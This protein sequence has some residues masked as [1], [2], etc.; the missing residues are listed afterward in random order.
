MRARLQQ[1][2]R[3]LLYLLG[4]LLTSILALGV[5]I[6]GLSIALSLAVFIVAIPA[7]VLVAETFRWTAEL[8]RQNARLLLGAPITSGYRRAPGEGVWG[9]MKATLTD[10]Q[11]FRD[12][13]WLIVH[14]VVGMTFGIL[15]L[16]LVLEPFA[17]ATLPGWWDRS[18]DNNV[19]QWLGATSQGDAWLVAL[20]AIPLALL[21]VVLL[22]GM[23]SAHVGLAQWFLH[24]RS[25][26]SVH[27]APTVVVTPKT[28]Y[29]PAAAIA[30]HVSVAAAI[31]LL[32][33]VIW[34]FTGGTF[35]PVW[36]W[37]GL[38]AS[39]IAHVGVVRVLQAPDRVLRLRVVAELAA[40]LV[41]LC[42]LVWLLTGLGT[43]WPVWPAIGLAAALGF[44]ALLIAAPWR[45]DG[46]LTER[47]E[48]LT[49]TRRDAVDAQATELRRIERDL[50]D[51][52][53]ARLVALTMQLGR[54][55]A[56]LADHP[57]EAELVRQARGEASAAI[58]ELRDL[59]R[60]IAPPVLVD[61]GLVAAVEALAGR[62]PMP[63]SVTA[64]VDQRLPVA[65]E[66]A[67]YFVCAEALTNAAKHASGADV[68]IRLERDATSLLVS[69]HD[70]GPGG[71]DA[72]GSGLTGLRQRVAALDGTLHV[73]SASGQGTT[74]SA[75]LSC[76]S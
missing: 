61:R 42:V 66:N 59:S 26:D 32:C 62:S 15:A 34:A 21:A 43:F 41:G 46:Q 2:G 40:A 8:D 47:I 9:R 75:E 23:A 30:V 68:A 54:A 49:R 31:G 67:A 56:R 58:A 6:A 60:G 48:T 28:P 57:E 5:W 37:F 18:D 25:A 63:V 55:E 1:A 69:V 64:N 19:Q 76:A 71:A 22:R 3:D 52:A 44:A 35:W 65:V 74:I 27:E 14:S 11:T 12:T 16:V 36:V 73:A 33:T 53:Q 70:T 7:I 39:V 38:L 72:G 17:F 29:E 50:H 10:P 13:A 20:L 4:A 51:G 24:A 45:R